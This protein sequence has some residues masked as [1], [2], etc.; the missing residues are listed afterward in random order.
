MLVMRPTLHHH[1]VGVLGHMHF[2]NVMLHKA[3]QAPVK[4]SGQIALH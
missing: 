1:L 2:M 3:Q 4:I